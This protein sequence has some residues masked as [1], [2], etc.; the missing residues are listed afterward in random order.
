MARQAD[1]ETHPGPLAAGMAPFAGC[2][3]RPTWANMLVL[4]AGALLSP[5]RRTVAAALSS[6]GLRGAATFTNYHRVLNRSRW[7]G[8]DAARCLLGLLVA[9]FAPSGPVVV[10]IDETIE[11]RWGAKIKARGI[12][13]DPVRSSRGHFV[14][15]SGLRWISLMLLAPV[16][17]VGRVWALPFLTALA[18]SERYAQAQGQG[19]RHKLL[20]DRA[21]QLLLLLARWLPGRQVIVVA[22]SS[23]A[24]IDLL[25]AVR[26]HVTVITRLRLDARLFD[27]PPPRLPGTKGRPRVSGARQPTL[28]Q[29]LADPETEWQ[30]VTVAGWYGQTERRLDVVS[31][32]ALWY[33]PGKQVPVRWLLVRDV[34]GEFEPQALLKLTRSGGAFHAFAGGSFHADHP[35][36]VFAGVPATD[37]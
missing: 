15:A 11:R 13:R 4:V 30:R 32:T 14:K 22:D 1:L 5:G 10:G 8:Q 23:Y 17:F 26:R 31:G 24:A 9:A 28:L 12:Y 27:P 2:F 37:H 36:P 7:S 6:V 20:T 3:T 21:R 16:P 34:A 35:S 18:P 25:A 33:H 19:R 29:R